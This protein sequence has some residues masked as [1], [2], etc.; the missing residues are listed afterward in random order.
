MVPK[1]W[2]FINWKMLKDV[3]MSGL[4]MNYICNHIMFSIISNYRFFLK[5]DWLHTLRLRWVSSFWN[6]NKKN[7]LYLFYKCIHAWSLSCFYK[8]SEEWNLRNKHHFKDMRLFY[9][10]VLYNRCHFCPQIMNDVLI[11]QNEPPCTQIIFLTF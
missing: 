3:L 4:R 1:M 5:D 11:I 6:V 10:S 2:R 8:I 7:K 9:S